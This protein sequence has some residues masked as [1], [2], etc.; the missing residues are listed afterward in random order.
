MATLQ[1]IQQLM[2]EIGPCLEVQAVLQDADGQHWSIEYDSEIE[3]EMSYDELQNKL[4]LAADIGK[5]CREWETHTYAMLLQYNALWPE[6]SGM[7]IALSEMHGEL[8]QLFDLFVVDLDIQTLQTVVVN[9]YE[10]AVIWR[11]VMTA[12]G[13][14]IEHEGTEETL[15]SPNHPLQS[16]AIRV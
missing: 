5:P 14:P 16:G 11:K 3:I 1:H 2:A 15:L 10:R 7:R 8:V 12:G 9:F 13:I 6:T 4:T